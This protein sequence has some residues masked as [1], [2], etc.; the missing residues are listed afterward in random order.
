MVGRAAADGT[1]QETLQE[2]SNDFV[3]TEVALKMTGA[4]PAALTAEFERWLAALDWN[5]IARSLD[6]RGY[7]TIPALLA[8]ARCDELAAMYDQRERFRSRVVMER[9]R[10]GV[11]EYKYFAPPLPALVGTLRAALYPRLAPIANRWG[12]VM[13]RDEA[14][15]ADLERFLE[16]CRRAGQTKPT[17]LLL[18]Y[19]AG[20][21]NCLHQ[22]LYGE[23]AFPIQLTCLL[24]RGGI[25]FSGGEFLL[26]ENRPRA[27]SRGE[28]VTLEQG[29]AI[30]FATSER[31][32]AGIRG[33]YRVMMRHGVSRVRHGRR[34][35]LGI[36]FHD[37]K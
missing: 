17:P 14:Y 30:I 13:G 8:P 36:I 33:H 31:P 19:D 18:R 9:V 26:V 27:Q 21:Y 16:I 4:A 7:A 2:T 20:G 11:G 15:P 1:F 29:E 32:I 24:S 22:D 6:E 25:D 28:A 23:V 37:A 3:R 34:L 5:A 10:F 35:A 12:R